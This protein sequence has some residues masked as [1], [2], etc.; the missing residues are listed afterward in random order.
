MPRPDV[1]DERKTQIL[2]A[3]AEL[4]SRNGIHASSMTEIALS[5]KLSKAAVYHYYDSKDAMVEALVRQLFDSDQPDVRKLIGSRR[6]A[7]LCGR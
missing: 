2:A 1:S 4:F 5:A 3:A 6:C 7:R